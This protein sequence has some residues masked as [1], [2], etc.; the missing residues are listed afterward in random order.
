MTENNKEKDP[1]LAASEGA[2]EALEEEP[3]TPASA[4]PATPEEAPNVASPELEAAMQEALASLEKRTAPAAAEGPPPPTPKELELKMQILD[5]QRRVRQLEQDL[6][7]RTSEVRQNFEQGQR[8]K[9][10]LEGFRA[11]VQKEKA[12]WFNYGHEPLAR[13]ILPVVDNLERALAHAAR[14]EDYK[15]L[16][17]GVA[18]T[19][20][21][22]L[23]VLGKFGIEPITALGQP[24]NPAFHEA[25]RAMESA[26]AAPNTVVEEHQKGYTLRDRLLRPSMVTISRRPSV[27]EGTGA[28]EEGEAAAGETPAEGIAESEPIAKGKD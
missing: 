27:P 18:L 14:P 2:P 9:E 6:E 4:A 25:M 20:R 16:R 11:R 12:D 13:E 1:E 28:A 21:L 15:A 10:H 24:F 23:Q 5:L 3:T 8:L 7:K 19:C 26:E 22:F 17:E